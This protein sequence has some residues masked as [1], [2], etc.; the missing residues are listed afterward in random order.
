VA[1]CDKGSL[2]RLGNATH[3]ALQDEPEKVNDL[4]AAFFVR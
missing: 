2:V 4:L 3:W 1:L